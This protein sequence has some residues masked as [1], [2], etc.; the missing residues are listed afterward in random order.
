MTES[1]KAQADKIMITYN[2]IEYEQL[3]AHILM[4][5]RSMPYPSDD[6]PEDHSTIFVKNSGGN[7]ICV[8]HVTTDASKQQVSLLWKSMDTSVR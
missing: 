7:N 2:I 3:E 4:S 6:D 1:Q 8:G 5:C